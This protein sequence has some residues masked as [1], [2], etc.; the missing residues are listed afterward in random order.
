MQTY[1]LVYNCGGNAGLRVCDLPLL[2]VVDELLI[3]DI[4]TNHFY[5]WTVKYCKDI[6][7]NEI[8][9]ERIEELKK[10]LRKN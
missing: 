7:I 3:T 9:K 10:E 4:L 6:K 2:Y 1:M 8:I 5:N